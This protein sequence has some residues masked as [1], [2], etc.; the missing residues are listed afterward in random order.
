MVNNNLLLWRCPVLT[1]GA[2]LVK[3]RERLANDDPVR[4]PIGIAAD[5]DGSCLVKSCDPR[6]QPS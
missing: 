3:V 4:R 1:F 5:A 6:L 2:V